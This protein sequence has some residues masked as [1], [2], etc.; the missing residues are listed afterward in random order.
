MHKIDYDTWKSLFSKFDFLL[1]FLYEPLPFFLGY[2]RQLNNPHFAELSQDVQI[3]DPNEIFST[4]GLADAIHTTLRQWVTE[5]FGLNP[6]LK[7]TSEKLA[8]RPLLK[9]EGFSPVG[10]L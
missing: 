9:M 8:D 5:T 3:R 1:S 10:L 2:S 4:D 6:N 7:L